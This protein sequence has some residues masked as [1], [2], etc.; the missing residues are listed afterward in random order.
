MPQTLDEAAAIR[1]YLDGTNKSDNF[2]QTR[3]LVGIVCENT[4]T[5]RL[6]PFEP[7]TENSLK[8][9]VNMFEIKTGNY[10]IDVT[11]S[12]RLG[13]DIATFDHKRQFILQNDQKCF[14]VVPIKK[15]KYQTCEYAKSQ[16]MQGLMPKY[17]HLNAANI[18]RGGYDK[19]SAWFDLAEL[20]SGVM[21]VLPSS[22]GGVDCKYIISVYADDYFDNNGRSRAVSSTSK[23]LYQK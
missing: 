2:Q 21:R 13:K 8:K 20:E 16:E 5:W 12:E 7:Q 4:T 17:A 6:Y 19:A 22:L 1:F 14:S 11:I 23:N 18:H 3:T 9:I 15:D 10:H